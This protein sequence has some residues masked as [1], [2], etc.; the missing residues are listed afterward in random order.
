MSMLGEI[1][2]LA[3]LVPAM[4]G[5]L[6]LSGDGR[7]GQLD[8]VLCHGG[9]I[10]IPLERGGPPAIAPSVCCAKGCRRRDK[11]HALDPEQ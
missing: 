8:I 5:P 6:A 2:G 9:T 1:V 11:R 7:A 3:A 10:A 4:A